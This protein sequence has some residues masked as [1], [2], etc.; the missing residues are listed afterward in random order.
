MNSEEVLRLDE[1][2]V[3]TSYQAKVVS[4]ERITADQSSE[5]VRELLLDV[6]RDDFPYKV[7]QSIGIR[8]PGAKEFGKE[9]H[10]RLYSV[11]DLPEVA[12]SGKPRIKICVKRCTYIDAYSGEQFDGVASNYLC[13]RNTGDKIEITGPFGLPFEVPE[14]KDANLILIGSGTGIAPF[15]A[16]IKHIYRDLPDWKGKVWLFYGAKSGLEMLYMN[17]LKNDFAQY[18]DEETFEAFKALSPRPNW[19]DPIA[20]DQAIMERAEELWQMM[21]DPKT[22]VFV[23]GLEKMRAQLDNVF[24]NIAGSPERWERRKAEL[25]AGKRWVELVY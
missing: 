25:V 6:E 19:A 7:G 3:G 4:S 11:A 13:D 15:R 9:H 12:D 5:E 18:Y 16:F 10:F 23:A 14:E 1:F 24:G 8:V 17:E 21:G 20:W 2:D 22:H